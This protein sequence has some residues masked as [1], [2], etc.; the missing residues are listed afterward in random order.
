MPNVYFAPFPSH[1]LYLNFWMVELGQYRAPHA[2]A[3]VPITANR[4]L[5]VVDRI[6]GTWKKALFLLVSRRGMERAIL[7][8][9]KGILYELYEAVSRSF[10]MH[11]RAADIIRLPSGTKCD[12]VEVMESSL[13]Q[14][15]NMESLD[16]PKFAITIFIALKANLHPVYT[17]TSGNFAY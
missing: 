16:R 2:L 10:I 6:N 13:G 3:S 4:T 8:S 11:A 12:A 9:I 17:V 15:W 7:A 1:Y 14:Q 5:T